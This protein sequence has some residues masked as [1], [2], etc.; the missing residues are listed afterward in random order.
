MLTQKYC[1]F[2]FVVKQILWN[3]FPSAVV[4]LHR[5]IWKYLEDKVNSKFDMTTMKTTSRIALL[6]LQNK[7]GFIRHE[8]YY[9]NYL[10]LIAKLCIGIYTNMV[11]YVK[12]DNWLLTPS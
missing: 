6:G 9:A 11:L 3:S 8:T 4:K 10:I 7:D 2:K 12:I 1:S 5:I